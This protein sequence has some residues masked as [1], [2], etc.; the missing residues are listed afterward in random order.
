MKI[1]LDDER[2]CPPGWIHCRWPQEV[3]R[4]LERGGVTHVSLDH[5]LGD[6]ESSVREGRTERTGYD[7]I[8]WIEEQVALHGFYPPAITVHSA[9][10][11]RRGEMEAGIRSI[12]RLARGEGPFEG[13]RT[14][15][16]PRDTSSENPP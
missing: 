7:V 14:S 10:A 2:P 1:Y 9:N 5:D 12:E 6:A 15:R 8:L 16:V 3:I 4:L 11:G 13:Q